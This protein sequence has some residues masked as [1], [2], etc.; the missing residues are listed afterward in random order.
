MGFPLIG[1]TIQ[2]LLPSNSIDIPAFVKTRV[3]RYGPLFKTSLM[4]WPVVVLTDPEFCYNLLQKDGELVERWRSGTSA[5]VLSQDAN[6]KTAVLHTYKVIKNSIL[7]RFGFEPL[8]NGTFMAELEKTISTSMHR[9]SEFPQVELKTVTSTMIFNFMAKK[10]FSYEPD[11]IPGSEELA[12]NFTNFFEEYLKFPINIPHITSWRRCFKA[13]KKLMSIIADIVENRKKFPREKSE[14]Y[15][16]DILTMRQ[17]EDFWTDNFIVIAL[18]G[19]LLASFETISP[20]IVTTVKFL[21]EYPLVIQKLQEENEKILKNREVSSKSGLSWEEYKSMT[22]TR[23]VIK[24]SLRISSVNPGILRKALTD[25]DV[26][27]YTIPKGWGVI[28]VP[29]AIQLSSTAYEDPLS[30][31]RHVGRA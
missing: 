9:W 21:S 18:F 28:V 15:L 10:L 1:E 16:D 23:H 14:D 3:Q 19:L 4:G 29:S 24:E 31:I 6:S 27:G 13:Q 5:Q 12:N 20:T 11:R 26:D 22:Y 30:L 8:K 25:I 7:G 17:K 2:F